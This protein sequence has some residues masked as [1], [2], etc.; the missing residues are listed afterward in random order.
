MNF[1]AKIGSILDKIIKFFSFLAGVILAFILLS[2]CLEVLMRYFLNRPLQWVVELTEYAL[3][4]IT[5]LGT[6]WLLKREGHIKVDV[7]LT[8]FSPKAQA[9]LKIFSYLIGIIV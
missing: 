8:L 9:G 1:L 3:L 4:F 2:V 7:F 6:A 5:F